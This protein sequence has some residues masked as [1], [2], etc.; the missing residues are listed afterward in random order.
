MEKKTIAMLVVSAVILILGIVVACGIGRGG[1]VT[2]QKPGPY[3]AESSNDN[4]FLNFILSLLCIDF[5]SFTLYDSII[6]S[7]LNIRIFLI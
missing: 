5:H 7:N 3:T 6:L 4:D 1:E 2:Y